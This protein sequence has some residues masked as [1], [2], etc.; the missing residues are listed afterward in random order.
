MTNKKYYL[1]GFSLVVLL[2]AITIGASY[3]YFTATVNNDG[4]V[5]QTA[6]TTGHMELLFS[7]GQD[8]SASGLIPGDSVTKTFKVKNIGDIDTVFDV[9]LSDVLNTFLDKTDLKYKITGQCASDNNYHQAPATTGNESKIIS[10]CSITP[11]EEFE[12]TLEIYF[13][14]DNT[15]QDDNKGKIF[16]AKIGINEYEINPN[17]YGDSILSIL[18]DDSLTSG[19]YTFNVTGNNGIE[20]TSENYP[21]HL[22]VLDGNQT[23]S[24]N[25]VYGDSSDVGTKD[26]YAQN[27]VIV[28][29]NGDYT[30]NSDVTVNPY[31]TAYGGPKGFTLYV[32]GKLTNNGIIDNS[33]GA[34]AKGQDV[35]LWKNTGNTYEFVPKVGASG[36]AGGSENYDGKAGISGIGRQTGGGGGGRSTSIV[37][38]SG[39]AGTS[40]SGG[41]GSGG[42]G[43][44]RDYDLLVPNADGG[45]GGNGNCGGAGSGNPAG[46]SGGA[47]NGTGGLLIIY[48]NEF[49]CPGKL[50]AV[51]SSGGSGT[52]HGGSSGG[53][54]INVFY[55]I[56]YTTGLIEVRGG[57]TTSAGGNGTYNHGSIATGTYVAG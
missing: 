23:I 48:S 13:E 25:T 15:N 39:A 4:D 51:G 44:G 50:R 29:V 11:N 43:C 24:E 34:Y 38:P 21:V 28:K 32:T 16:N 7:D 19:Y 26:S 5:N 9:Y 33:H 37:S 18:E 12:Y 47:S 30:I 40:Y 20:T 2:I 54:S 10:G 6:I 55:N 49:D 53:G 57:T 45:K 1:I 8:V 17:K 42:N 14:D 35:Y 56:K 36:G 31:Y 46:S 27:M 3:A 52:Y 41:T 22:Y